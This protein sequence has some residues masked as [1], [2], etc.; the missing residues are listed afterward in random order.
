M[1]L[2]ANKSKS[3]KSKSIRCSKSIGGGFSERKS[4]EA[5]LIMRSPS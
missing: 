4:M 3:E 1:H 2:S 5:G